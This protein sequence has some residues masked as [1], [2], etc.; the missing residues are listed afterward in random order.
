APGRS[1][2]RACSGTGRAAQGG[3]ASASGRGPPRG[4]GRLLARAVER[5]S[6]RWSPWAPALGQTRSRALVSGAARCSGGRGA[7]LRGGRG[8]LLRGDRGERA[9]SEQRGPH[10]GGERAAGGRFTATALCL[11]HTEHGTGTLPAGGVPMDVNEGGA[12][13]G[14]DHR[15]F[16][17]HRRYLEGPG[18]RRRAAP[19]GRG[20]VSGMVFGG[21]SSTRNPEQ[22][23]LRALDESRSGKVPGGSCPKGPLASSAE[24]PSRSGLGGRPKRVY[25]GQSS[26][27][28][29]SGSGVACP[30]TTRVASR[31]GPTFQLSG[32]SDANARRG[33]AAGE[34]TTGSE[35]C[36]RVSRT[37]VGGS[38]S[39]RSSR[40]PG[41]DWW[42]FGER[43]PV[44]LPS[45]GVATFIPG[46][47]VGYSSG[48]KP[49]R[50]LSS[51]AVSEGGR[52]A[53]PEDKVLAV[54]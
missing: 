46:K 24:N 38:R 27:L 37:V 42:A 31:R 28:C 1:R 26:D 34:T 51:F 45:Y 4:S 18:G 43:P 54:A 41:D 11:V 9:R 39:C 12:A 5:R 14:T 8:A 50:I 19:E 16:P 47:G 13:K 53:L 10:L 40:A 48:D 17:E 49:L 36:A 35:P 7:L 22:G 21:A 15:H 25:D 52:Y 33:P 3:A 32:L 6:E 44:E 30:W 23:S 2:R 20:W 29:A